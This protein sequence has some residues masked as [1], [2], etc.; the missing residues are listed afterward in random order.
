MDES[1][2][3][4]YDWECCRSMVLTSMSRYLLPP[5]VNIVLDYYV[6]VDHAL[7]IYCSLCKRYNQINVGPERPFPLGFF[8]LLITANDKGIV[9]STLQ[10]T[11]SKSLGCDFDAIING[12][13]CGTAQFKI[14]ELVLSE[15]NRLDIIN[16]DDCSV[17]WDWKRLA[18]A[19]LDDFITRIHL[20]SQFW[21]CTDQRLHYL[22]RMIF[23]E[24]TRRLI[25]LYFAK[26][27]AKY[28]DNFKSYCL[29]YNNTNMH[30]SGRCKNILYLM[31][32]ETANRFKLKREHR[33]SCK[34]LFIGLTPNIKAQLFG[35]PLLNPF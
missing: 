22:L 33:L 32:F 18:F 13:N 5:L 1:V 10:R 15:W 8:G 31:K 24:N 4:D 25:F 27:G 35:K 6:S 23:N 16:N 9:N 19:V 17:Y 28:I 34:H 14:M 12:I 29:T 21:L 11:L 20:D 26:R 7:S 30:V 3:V 2:D